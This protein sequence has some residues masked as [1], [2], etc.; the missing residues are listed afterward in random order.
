MTSASPSPKGGQASQPGEL[1][2]RATSGVLLVTLTA[3]LTVAGLWPFTLMIAAGGAILAWEWGQL[4]RNR[5]WDVSFYIHAASVVAACIFTAAAAPAWIPLGL[6]GAGMLGVA[7][8]GASPAERVW[9]ALG[10]L[11]LGIPCC[12]LIAFRSDPSFGIVAV[13]FLFL[14][15][16]SAD[17][18]AYFVGRT[19]RGPKLAPAISPGKTW[20][21]FAG[22]L[23][24]PTLLAYGYALW[25]GGTSAFGV[26]LTG[27]GLAFASQM[28]DLAE[29]AIKRTF[30]VKDSGKLLPGHGGLFDRADGLV[31]AVLAAGCLAWF[32]NTLTPA[33]SFLIWP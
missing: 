17:T 10:V 7:F 4:T 16:W 6:L 19:L 29:S 15:V 5:A 33:Q 3:I 22:G 24:V 20:S 13:F 26:A 23:V 11:Y 14:V 18:A 31:G 30:D 21:G 2:K 32:R 28:G 9:S 8:L 27:V 1:V 25:L 12:L